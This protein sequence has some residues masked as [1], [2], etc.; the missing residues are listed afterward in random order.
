MHGASTG[1]QVAES[2]VTV[3][4]VC[5]EAERG[6]A[7]R[8]RFKGQL[9]AVSAAVAGRAERPPSV[10]LLEWLDPPFDGG[11]CEWLCG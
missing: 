4:E 11:H 7:L 10:L 3:A 8:A 6:E 9:A 5:G 2:F 1:A